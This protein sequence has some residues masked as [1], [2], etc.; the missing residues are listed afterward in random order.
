MA[1]PTLPAPPAGSGGRCN[2][3][4]PGGS[5]LE[6]FVWVAR[7]YAANGGAFEHCENAQILHH[8]A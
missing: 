8:A 7:F 1:V 2:D 5:T 6:R 3:Y 4:L